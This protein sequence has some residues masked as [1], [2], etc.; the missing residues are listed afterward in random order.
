METLQKSH[1][2]TDDYFLWLSL[3]HGYHHLHTKPGDKSEATMYK[4]YIILGEF[5]QK[6]TIRTKYGTKEEY[7]KLLTTHGMR[8]E[9]VCRYCIDHL[10][11]VAEKTER[12]L[13]A[14]YIGRPDHVF[15]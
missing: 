2:E 4:I 5:D 7:L 15:K 6:G 8:A 14:R 3:L 10:G 13:Y 9:G 11:V 12:F 1:D